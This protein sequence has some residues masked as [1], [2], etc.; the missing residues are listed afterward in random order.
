MY[1][2]HQVR[3]GLIAVAVLLALLVTMQPGHSQPY[4]PGGGIRGGGP[5]LPGPA[6][7]GPGGIRGG[8]GGIP[9]RPPGFPEV[10]RPPE[11]PRPPEFPRLPEMPQPPG[12][13]RRPGIGGPNIYDWTCSRCGAHLGTGPTPPLVRVCPNCGARLEGSEIVD[14]PGPRV[15]PPGVGIPPVTPPGPVIP[16][17]PGFGPPQFEDPGPGD[18]PRAIDGGVYVPPSTPAAG[19][20]RRATTLKVVGIAMGVLLLLGILIGVVIVAVLKQQPARKRRPRPRRR[21]D[22]DDE[23]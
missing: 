12:F 7:P 5:G 1:R 21:Y 17:A 4:P 22:D 15:R 18:L 23:Y 2:A 19:E 13:G 11:M 3:L 20:S 16:P 14:P 8:I 9:G 10:P 6:M